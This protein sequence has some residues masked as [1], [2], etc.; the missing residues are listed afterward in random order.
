MHFIRQ[1]A[2]RTIDDAISGAHTKRLSTVLMAIVS[3]EGINDV[4]LG[5]ESIATFQNSKDKC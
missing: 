3:L 4:L 2:T 1:Q 5:G